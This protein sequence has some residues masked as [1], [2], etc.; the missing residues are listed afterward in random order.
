MSGVSYDEECDEACGCGHP[1]LSGGDVPVRPVPLP[2]TGKSTQEVFEG[3]ET[4]DAE[5]DDRSPSDSLSGTQESRPL[6]L[7]LIQL[8]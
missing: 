7:F 2:F 3:L 4:G 5:T 8:N 6:F 1:G